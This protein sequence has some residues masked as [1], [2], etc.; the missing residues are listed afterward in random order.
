MALFMQRYSGNKENSEKLKELEKRWVERNKPFLPN[1]T[2]HPHTILANYRTEMAFS[3]DHVDGELD[4]D[5]LTDPFDLE[6]DLLK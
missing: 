1:D 3:E 5:F 6:E 2:R 4:W